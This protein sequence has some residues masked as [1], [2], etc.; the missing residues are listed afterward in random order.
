MRKRSLNLI[1]SRYK[2]KATNSMKQFMYLALWQEDV[3]KEKKKVKNS[4][5]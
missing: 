4:G 5:G 1:K 2:R 3:P